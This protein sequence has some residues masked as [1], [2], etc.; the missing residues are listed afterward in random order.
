MKTA[1]DEDF[2]FGLRVTRKRW[3]SAPET[4]EAGDAME[5]VKC[6]SGIHSATSLAM[7]L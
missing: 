6:G 2:D 3:R 7:V 4:F 1:S 5:G